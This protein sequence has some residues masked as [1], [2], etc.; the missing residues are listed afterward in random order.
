MQQILII[1]II[2]TQFDADESHEF[3]YA[4]RAVC[5]CVRSEWCERQRT[6]CSCQRLHKNW[7]R[8]ARPA[9]S[10]ANCEGRSGDAT[11]LKR[12]RSTLHN[13]NEGE[14]AD[15]L[16]LWLVTAN[17]SQVE[18]CAAVTT[19]IAAAAD[20]AVK[21]NE[22]EV[23]PAERNGSN[24]SESTTQASPMSTVDCER[25]SESGCESALTRYVVIWGLFTRQ[26]LFAAA[27]A[28]ARAVRAENLHGCG[29]ERILKINREQKARWAQKKT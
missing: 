15:N 9:R 14:D 21:A 8:I 6:M 26:Q 23:A 24:L 5:M 20:A 16:K 19:A 7:A 22:S 2:I 28:A 25:E 18:S 4:T 11:E 17:W 3:A 13:D 27:A 10:F 12:E 1:I 29:R